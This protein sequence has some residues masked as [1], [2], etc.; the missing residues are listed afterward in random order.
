MTPENE[1]LVLDN[2]KLVKFV[3][4]KYVFPQV[5]TRILSK[6]VTSHYVEQLRLMTQKLVNS[7]LGR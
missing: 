7:Q 6:K 1:R 3:L 4:G 5:V 2:M